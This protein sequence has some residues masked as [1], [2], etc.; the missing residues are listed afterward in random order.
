MTSFN[1]DIM[2]WTKKYHPRTSKEMVDNYDARILFKNFMESWAMGRPVRKVLFIYGHSGNGK[3]SIVSSF[4]EQHEITTVTI[5]PSAYKESDKVIID[6]NEAINTG[7]IEVGSRGIKII[8]IDGV[9]FFDKQTT[10]KMWSMVKDSKQPVILIGDKNKDLEYS[11]RRSC[12]EVEVIRPMDQD[13]IDHLIHIKDKEGIVI[14]DHIL[15]LICKASLSVR[16][17]IS[18]LQYLSLGSITPDDLHDKIRMLNPEEQ[19]QLLLSGKDVHFTL[20][21]DDLQ[22]WVLDNGGSPDV[23]A[24]SD[25][26][27]GRAILTQNYKLWKYAYK[28]LSQCRSKRKVKYPRMYS[29]MYKAKSENQRA[30]FIQDKVE[31]QKMIIEKKKESVGA[32]DDFF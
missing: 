9:Q 21:P 27:C 2:E 25:V 11:Y 8:I 30:R 7:S 31:K 23:V 26:F 28:I 24:M 3:N 14:E 15:K 10:K 1:G 12:L 20:T 29:Q 16:S 13:L 4:C 17:A 5:D 6:I 18:N 22:V 19:V 32:L